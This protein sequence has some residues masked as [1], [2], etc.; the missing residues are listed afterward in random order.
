MKY[1]INSYFFNCYPILVATKV[2]AP[3]V[4]PMGMFACTFNHKDILVVGEQGTDIAQPMVIHFAI[5]INEVRVYRVAFAIDDADA[6]I[7]SIVE[8]VSDDG[9]ACAFE[10]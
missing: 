1:L 9:N 2:I 7:A 5:E 6:A 10:W 8:C 3:L 4:A